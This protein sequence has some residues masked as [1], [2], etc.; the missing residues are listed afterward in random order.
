MNYISK[1]ILL[2]LVL[3]ITNI[4]YGYDMGKEERLK[5]FNNS[6]AEEEIGNYEKA[7]EI[8]KVLYQDNQND[9]LVNIRLGWLF[10]LAKKNESSVKYYKEAVRISKNSVEAL[11]GLTYPYSAMNDWDEIKQ[12][13]K[14]ILDV[15]PQHYTSN[16]NLAKIYFNT[17]DYLNS[18]VILEKLSS[19]YPSDYAINLY[20]GWSYYYLGSKSKGYDHFVT[21]L[22]VNPNDASAKEGL[23]LTR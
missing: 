5:T 8:M 10:Y 11:L 17:A 18:K 1:V 19:V 7:I 13:Y 20:L 16:L 2:L 14:K 9:Y 22:I 3:S 23:S 15:D 6:I 4:Q 12:I 21:A